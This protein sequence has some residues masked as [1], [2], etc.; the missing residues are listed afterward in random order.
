MRAALRSF[1][2]RGYAA[3]SVQ[4]IAR[5]ARVSKPVLYYY[6]QNKA[7]LYQAL[8]DQAHDERYR[9]MQ[10]AA[11]RGGDIE[12]Q[13]T[14]IVQ[15]LFD[16]SL[17]NGEL[18]RLA[19]VNALSAGGGAPKKNQCREKG[20][21]NFEFI[22]DLIGQGQARG[23]VT[24]EFSVEQLAMGIYG[25]L[26][27]YIMVRLIMPQLPLTRESAAGIVKL[28]FKGAATRVPPGKSGDGGQ[29]RKGGS[30]R[31]RGS[32]DFSKPLDEPC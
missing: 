8:V 2:E 20:V 1:A 30:T 19:F 28:F 5:S 23:E 9:L 6:F 4:Q 11:A 18:M 31:A 14:E 21:R 17:R 32:R 12:A 3:T 15:A 29:A 25:Q 27:T 7:G 13:L 10:E 26:S 22:R 24:T 16:F